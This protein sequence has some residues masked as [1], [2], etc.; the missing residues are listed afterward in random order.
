MSATVI[1]NSLQ[2]VRQRV[3]VLSVLHGVGVW[4]AVLVG[5]LLLVVGLDY[6]LNL[7]PLLRLLLS[8][9]ALAYAINLGVH[10]IVWPLAAK[11]RL[12][13]VAGKV[14]QTF[15]AFKDSLRS[16]VDFWTQPTAGSKAMQDRVAEQAEELARGVDLKGVVRPQ[17]ALGAMGAGI[18]ALILS[19]LLA[20]A[21]G[22]EYLMVAMSRLLTPFEGQ[23][24]PKRTMIEV[25]SPTPNR[26]AAGNSLDLRIRLVKGDKPSAKTIVFYQLERNGPVEQQ[27]MNRNSDG[28]FSA[29]LDAQLDSGRDVGVM[30]VWMRSGDDSKTLS[31]IAVMPKLA[32]KR[33]EAV[34]APPPYADLPPQTFDLSA[35]SPTITV[36]SRVTL[37]I[38]F[39]K[40]L[41]DGPSVHL[42]SIAGG[43]P[44]IVWQEDFDTATGMFLA[45]DPVHFRIRATDVDGFDN[46]AIEEY[47]I[48]TRPDQPPSVQL[49][50]PVRNEECTPEAIVPLQAVAEDDFGIKTLD[51]MASR[52]TDQKQWTSSLVAGALAADPTVAWRKLDSGGEFSSTGADL[53]RWRMN[54]TWDLA[55][56]DGGPLRPGDQLEY[57]LR[58]ADN[59]VDNQGRPHDPPFSESGRLRVTIISQDQLTQRVTDLLAQLRQT[60]DELRKQNNALAIATKG[61][62]QDTATKRNLDKA[63]RAQAAQLANDQSATASQT[64][65]LANRLGETLARLNENKSP[66]TDLANNVADAQRLLNDAAENAMQNAAAQ[67]GQ[68]K[69][70]P[71]APAGQRNQALDQAQQN[72][73]AADAK[74]QAAMDKMGAETGVSKFLSQLQNLLDSQKK[75]SGDTTESGKNLLGK[76]PSQ[77]TP[78]EQK[79]LSDL[80]DRQSELARQAEQAMKQMDRAADQQSRSDPNSSDALKQAAQTG[81][82]QN[83]SGNMNQAADSARQNQ[84]ADAQSAQQQAQ[85]GLM[86]MLRQLKDA[87]NRRLLELVKQLEDAQQLLADLLQQQA[88]HNLDNLMLQG[89]PAL[90]S[91]AKAA[92]ELI[93]ELVNWSAR[94][95]KKMPPPPAIDTQIALQAQTERNA[96]NIVLK[97]QALPRGAEPAADLTR[98]AQQMSRAVTYLQGQQLADAYQPPQVEAFAALLSA[99]KNVDEQTAKAQQ[100]IQDRQ[101]ESLRQAFVEIRDQQVKINGQTK[102]VDAS[103][104]TPDGQLAHRARAEVGILGDQQTDLSKRTSKLD[105]DL[106][107]VGSIAYTYVNDDIVGRM[108]HVKAQLVRLDPGSSTQQLQGRIVDELNDMIK[109]LSIKPKQSPFSNTRASNASSAGGGG[110]GAPQP[111]RLPPEAEIR[112]IQ[113]MQRILNQDTKDAGSAKPLDKAAVLDLGQRQGELRKLLSDILSKSSEG[114]VDLGPEPANKDTLPEEAKDEEL[115]LQELKDSALNAKP[116]AQGVADDTAMLGVRMARARQRL[117]LDSDPGETTQRIQ[118]RIMIEMD[119]L[120]KMA[121]QQEQTT[122]GPRQPR[123]GTEPGQIARQPGQPDNQ[124]ANGQRA[125]G[126]KRQGGSNPATANNPGPG[127]TD[128]DINARLDDLKDSWGKLSPRQRAAVMEGPTDKTIQKFKDFVD[129]YYRTLAAKSDDQSNQPNDG[130]QPGDGQQ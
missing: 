109:D 41:A 124:Q 89:G 105:D 99:K 10:R 23:A 13:D 34:V 112:L 38:E 83:V 96:R 35:A 61:L 95:I 11:L 36:G 47:Q 70:Q 125:Q 97:I 42:E 19:L 129:G 2:S 68:L 6:L 16:T 101:K 102:V 110:A 40:E 69:D 103:G 82:Q 48:Y 29:S 26:I 104:R 121:Q 12:G 52:L 50:R 67:I 59:F 15:P 49:E 57:Y 123:P 33:V 58:V 62:R 55:K 74:L 94:D 17:P 87:E 21:V 76:D 79:K 9:G 72:Q 106:V 31:P 5:L 20:W 91:A 51:L 24:W 30:T 3:R 86:M 54:W 93:V 118:E 77:L 8:L 115:D 108:N 4:L 43:V 127:L 100:Q 63:D 22:P 7:P 56:L 85:L 25:I 120:A 98:A 111:P 119:A 37:K 18:A 71:N 130:Q 39:N 90:M 84:Q 81:Q 32:I 92:P 78:D 122:T 28:S 88:G 53:L 1:L 107:A 114:Q 27:L 116:D 66:N 65:E 46:D 60:T 75:L 80:A 128:Q 117:A 45:K 64:K 113:D 14:E 73:A 44:P 126:P